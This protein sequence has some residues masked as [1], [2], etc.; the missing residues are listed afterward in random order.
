MD[1]RFGNL[2]LSPSY[3]A[4]SESEKDKIRQ[5]YTVLKTLDPLIREDRA[6]LLAIDSLH[7]YTPNIEHL[8]RRCAQ[9]I[10][11]AANQSKLTKRIDQAERRASI[12]EKS[13]VQYIPNS[14]I[15][16][17]EE[18]ER[19]ETQVRKK[20]NAWNSLENFDTSKGEDI[21]HWL[22]KLE[23]CFEIDGLNEDVKKIAVIKLKTS[24]E[25]MEYIENLDENERRDYQRVTTL[26][27][28]KYNGSISIQ[29][30]Q[31][32]LRSYRIDIREEKFYDSCIKLGDLVKVA[33]NYIG[34]KDMLKA[35]LGEL[36]K[37]LRFREDLWSKLN[38]N[39][40]YKSF[41]E[42][43]RDLESLLIVKNSMNK[44][45]NKKFEKAAE[46]PKLE[47]VNVKCFNCGLVGHYA[48]NCPKKVSDDTEVNVPKQRRTFEASEKEV[49]K[50]DDDKV[51][52]QNKLIMDNLIRREMYRRLISEEKK[53]N[54]GNNEEKIEEN[55]SSEIPSV[56]EGNDRTMKVKEEEIL[57][58]E[59]KGAFDF[60][61]PVQCS[62][63]NNIIALVDT[64]ATKSC[65][66]ESRAVKLGFNKR[67]AIPGK[68]MMMNGEIL[69]TLGTFSTKVMFHNLVYL[70]LKM[71]VVR[72]K[73]MGDNRY[74]AVLGSDALLA[75]GATIDYLNKRIEIGGRP[76]ITL[77]LDSTN[78]K[79]TG[80]IRRCKEE[81]RKTKNNLKVDLRKKPREEE[82]LTFKRGKVYRDNKSELFK[83]F[84]EERGQVT[85]R[86]NWRNSL[87]NVSEPSKC[88][89]KRRKFMNDF[90]EDG[91][92]HFKSHILEEGSTSSKGWRSNKIVLRKLQ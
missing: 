77:N 76:L 54:K 65:I 21:D 16:I 79:P 48:S 14:K 52:E 56:G 68:C 85:Y 12:E 44:N 46:R 74:S 38:N 17:V 62:D 90:E 89:W 42:A 39:P 64:G 78:E 59:V 60:Y 87:N 8:R 40:S 66:A 5:I 63:G 41:Q 9:L 47:K 61:V 71:N 24:K 49:K 84:H 37:A 22:K 43:A 4:V 23:C 19:K 6:I 28:E 72:D 36:E 7:F 30:A 86:C 57:T 82:D 45:K 58:F 53:D 73:D 50:L 70:E 13:V 32:Q 1:D 25:I 83:N 15:E 20:M 91:I 69:E 80:I 29:N 51:S 35:Q 75:C 27:K 11:L 3:Q 10:V 2:E 92:N 33:Y 34:E 26:L 88:Y 81:N 18:S 67:K 31:A 55:E